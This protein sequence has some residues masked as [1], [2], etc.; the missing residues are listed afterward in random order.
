MVVSMVHAAQEGDLYRCRNRHRGD[1]HALFWLGGL[2]A[3]HAT[4]FLVL[5]HL[6]L[7]LVLIFFTLASECVDVC[8]TLNTFF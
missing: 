3:R 7:F 2:V 6:C 5:T 1:P 8:A 4:S